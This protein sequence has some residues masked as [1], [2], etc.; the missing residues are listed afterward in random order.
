MLLH[1]F[2]K[3][4]SIFR[5]DRRKGRPAVKPSGACFAQAFSP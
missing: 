3:K 5:G 1:Y 4:I 2:I